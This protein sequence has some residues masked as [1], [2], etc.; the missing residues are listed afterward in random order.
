MRTSG[1]R[2]RQDAIRGWVTDVAN[3]ALPHRQSRWHASLSQPAYNSLSVTGREARDQALEV[4]GF[5][6]TTAGLLARAFPSG[7]RV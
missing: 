2:T 3:Y 5:F 4:T 6:R 1:S 7:A